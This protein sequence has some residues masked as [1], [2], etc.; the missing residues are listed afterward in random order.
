MTPEQIDR[1]PFLPEPPRTTIR[2]FAPGEPKPGG[3]KTGIYIKKINRTV[4][5]EA[6]KGT[7]PWRA[8]VSL[9][10]REIYQGDPLDG[11]IIFWM[12]FTMPRP[13]YHYHQTG[14]RA[15]QLK[16][17]APRLHTKSPD[18]T[19]LVRSTEDALK[20]ICWR[21]DCQVAKQIVSKIYGERPGV[22]VIIAPMDDKTGASFEQE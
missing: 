9:A 2:F 14:K 16:D 21:D 6:C 22:D 13:K 4:M 18:A 19:K 8:V 17:N 20:S 5:I 7:K 11:P 1:E 10:A 3:S 15:G 12:T